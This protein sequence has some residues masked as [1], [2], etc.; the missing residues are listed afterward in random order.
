MGRW[1]RG[2]SILH[3]VDE[4]VKIPLAAAWLLQKIDEVGS[5]CDKSGYSRGRCDR[6]LDRWVPLQIM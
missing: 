5:V 1:G 4:G 3:S 6:A 2:Q